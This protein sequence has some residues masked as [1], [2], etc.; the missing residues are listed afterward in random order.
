MVDYILPVLF[1][2]LIVGLWAMF[3]L[4]TGRQ[5]DGT[6]IDQD[7]AVCNDC[8]APCNENEI[9]SMTKQAERL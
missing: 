4:W 6:A 3:Q 9:T 8:N 1:F 2:S 7:N 5:P